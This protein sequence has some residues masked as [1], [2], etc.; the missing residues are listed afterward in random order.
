[1][2]ESDYILRWV[3]RDLQ[4]L[5]ISNDL[6]RDVILVE[7]ARQVGKT[8]MVAHALRAI[9]HVW[10][11]LEREK[12][13]VREIDATEEFS[14]FTEWLAARKGFVPGNG[15]I[16]VIDEAQESRCLGGYVRSMKEEWPNQTVI[17]LGSLMARLFREGVRYPV[18]RVRRVHVYPFTFLEF[19]DAVGETDIKKRIDTWT[20]DAPLSEPFHLKAMTHFFDYLQIGGLPEVVSLYRSAKS[21]KDK[22]EELTYDYIEDFKRVEGEE[23]STLFE[24]TLKRIANTIGA[25]SKLSTLVASH[26]SGYRA[27]PDILTLLE[28]WSLVYKVAIDGPQLS[29]NNRTPPKRYL[30][31]HGIRQALSPISLQFQ[32][33]PQEERTHDFSNFGGIFENAVLN[34]LKR[35]EKRK[36]SS[37]RKEPN[38]SEVDFLCPLHQTTLPIEVKAAMK[39]NR[40]FF[41]PILNALD[42][43]KERV[44][45]LASGARGERYRFEEKEILQIPFYAVSRI[46]DMKAS[47]H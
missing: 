20:V 37:W 28:N 1:M 14:T 7:G 13:L 25:P 6:H 23:K 45:V 44:G 46:P 38:G 39:I 18:G 42:A 21:W 41:S 3:E 10:I 11:N 36:I 9:P 29:K 30:F 15:Q 19:L 35:F 22:L 34:E 24:H 33:S 16:L 43:L 32:S 27:L 5:L 26:Q 8:R 47:A 40:K 31:D 17:L 12:R 4:E 2:T